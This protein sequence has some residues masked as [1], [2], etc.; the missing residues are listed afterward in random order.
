[1]SDVFQLSDTLSTNLIAVAHAAEQQRIKKWLDIDAQV[2]TLLVA[3][4]SL[5]SL[6]HYNLK[7][8]FTDVSGDLDPEH[9]LVIHNTETGSDPTI[10][11][12]QPLNVIDT[13]LEALGNGQPPSYVVQ[14]TMIK[15]DSGLS[16][17]S[18]DVIRFE[19]FVADMYRDLATDV[20]TRTTEFWGAQVTLTGSKSRRAWLIDKLRDGLQAECEL[21]S[22]DDTLT[23]EQMQLV[24]QVL[25]YPTL[26][27]RGA[28]ATYARPA[29]YALELKGQAGLSAIAFAGAWV[30]TSRDGTGAED[31]SGAFSIPAKAEVVHIDAKANVGKV[32]LYTPSGGLQGFESLPALHTELERRWR[33]V[34][35]FESMLELVSL[36]DRPRILGLDKGPDASLEWMFSEIKESIFEHR[37]NAHDQQRQHNLTYTLSRAT[38]VTVTQLREDLARVLDYGPCFKQI[39]AFSARVYKKTAKKT[40]EWLLKASAEDRQA[41]TN[42]SELYNNQRLIADEEGEPS[43]H[44]FG[45]KPFLLNYAREQIRQHILLEYGIE[46]DPDTVFVTTTA[47]ERGSGPIIPVSTYGSSSYTAVNSL[48]RTGPS[49]KLVSVSRTMTQLAL[50]NVS[51]L[52]VDYALTAYVT[53]GAANGPRLSTLSASQI[54]SIIRTVNIGDNYEAFLKD[55][56]IDSPQAVS[57][58]ET[59]VQLRLAQMRVDA[60]EAKISMDFSPDRLDRGYRWVEALLSEAEHPTDLAVVEGHRIKA[61]QLLIGEV[62]VRGVL[63]IATQPISDYEQSLVK[64]SLITPQPLFSVSSLVVYTPEAPDGQRFREFENH[65]HLT[66]KFLNNQDFYDYFV[67]RVNQS[68]QANVRQLL[69]TGVRGPNARKELITG[70]LIEQM[71][72]ADVRYAIANADA[73]STSTSESNQM[74]AW[75]S[76]ETAL[77]IIS[78]VL[79]F[80]VTAVLALGRSLLSLWNGFDA[81][82]R[83]SQQEALGYFIGVLS[84]L[85]DAGVDIGV[86]IARQPL[87]AVASLALPPKIAYTKNLSGVTLR[88]DGVYAGIYEKV[89]KHGG[90]SQYFIQQEKHWYQVKYDKDRLVWRVIDMRRPQ[91]WYRSAIVQGSDDLWR[92]QTPLLYLRGGGPSTLAP[93]RVR[94]ALPQLSFEQ[95]RKFLDQF[96]FPGLHQAQL[97]L[98]LAEH[99]VKYKELPLW[100]LPYLKPDFDEIVA[101]AMAPSRASR[102]ALPATRR[103]APTSSETQQVHATRPPPASTS[104]A[105]VEELNSASWKQWGQTIDEGSLTPLSLYPP[106]FHVSSGG[107][108]YRAIKIDGLYYEALPQNYLPNLD[109]VFI[110]H[111]DKPINGY[112]KLEQILLDTPYLQP[113]LAQFANGVWKL[114]EPIFHKAI[115]FF[116][117]D[118]LPSL[119]L[120]STQLLAE[121]LYRAADTLSQDLT[122]NRLLQ[123]NRTLHGWR[124]GNV[125][126][127]HIQLGDPFAL[128]TRATT[129]GERIYKVGTQVTQG[130]F[131]RLDFTLL[132]D[133]HLLLSVMHSDPIKALNRTMRSLLERQGFK[134]YPDIPGL[135]ELVFRRQGSNTMSYMQLHT[136]NSPYLTLAKELSESVDVFIRK[137]PLAPL[138]LAMSTAKAE[139][140][141]ITLLGGVQTQVPI[142]LPIAFVYRV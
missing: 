39:K 40:R 86:A 95:A 45:N 69:T 78:I 31:A 80:K 64:L 4:P 134:I 8:T 50:E 41:W 90:Y 126:P 131:E 84:H 98:D 83:D 121:R 141:L 103:K 48:S 12:V 62:T 66:N 56:L 37:F 68:D 13:V 17:A 76:F 18:L 61:Y 11:L 70:N 47:A 7:N 65:S 43:P 113:R 135:T 14:Q 110:K 122:L 140:K 106:I 5:Y 38:T 132:A 59:N 96:N 2:Q 67:E 123:I 128:L 93:Y 1:M 111:P 52:D 21:L 15:S 142:G 112:K 129:L 73:L 22:Y 75:S 97:E 114:H 29:V 139:G 108:R 63:I 124:S 53:T 87:K 46:I 20:K 120:E 118:I 138:S 137:N 33:A 101:L 127:E 88:S 35:E 42:A 115:R 99:L 105:V 72:L 89:P 9:L 16:T 24:K 58:R 30:M 6:I 77:D 60:L 32:V 117:S 34:S 94:V 27:A 102:R 81:L 136:I 36:E 125:V 71:Y 49:I 82:K 54:K 91:A 44:Q 19:T 3:Q 28:L 104:T 133:E 23:P 74:T 25:R 26:T 107:R 130:V 109:R 10:T 55:K 92:V 85:V 119:T 116:I 51:K 57:R 100:S 79:P